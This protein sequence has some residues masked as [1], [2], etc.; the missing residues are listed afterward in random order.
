MEMPTIGNARRGDGWIRGGLALTVV[1]FASIAVS[2][3]VG[4]SSY[5]ANMRSVA[6]SNSIHMQLDDLV[7]SLK[8][9]QRGARGYIIT[10]D[11]LFLAPFREG[12]DNVR[13]EL[14]AIRNSPRTGLSTEGE[15]AI[16]QSLSETLIAAT[17]VEV[18]F[19][20]RGEP[21][22][23]RKAVRGGEP[24]R[25]MERVGDVVRVM[26]EKEAAM[27][28]DRRADA[29]SDF[30]QSLLYLLLGTAFNLTLIICM[31]MFMNRQLRN[32]RFSAETLKMSEQRLQT[33]INSVQEGITF[34]NSE[35]G[36]EVFNKRMHQIT[37]YTMEE[38]NRSGDFT[39]LLYPDPV[40]R[41]RALDGTREVIASPGPHMSE[42]TI[43]SKSGARR[44][45]QV[46]SQTLGRD[47]R[48]MFLTT[49]VDVTEQRGLEE[50]LR[51]S[52]EKF[53]LVFENAQDGINIFE[54]TADH[55]KRRLVECNPRYAELAGRSREELLAAGITSAMTVSLSGQNVASIEGGTAFSGAFSWIR[56]DGKE[57][58]IEYTA[59]PIIMRGKKFTIGIDRDVTMSRKAELLVHESQLRYQQLFEASPNPLM[60][61]DAGTLEFLQVNP[62]TIEHYGYS[63]EEF[64]SMTAKDIQPPEDVPRFLAVATAG[65]HLGER[66][67]TWRHRKKDGTIIKVRIKS[68]AIDWKG[69]SARL[70]LVHDITDLLQI[71]E[72]L[73]VQ[74]THFE[75]LFESAPE[76]IALLDGSGKVHDINR[77][78]A[79]MFGFTKDDILGR[80]ITDMTIPPEGKEVA[81]TA[82]EAVMEGVS[83]S[84][85]AQRSTKDGQ[86]IDVSIIAV[87]VD[88]GRG[89]NMAYV[90]YRDITQKKRGDREREELILQL[91]KAL[92]EVKTLGGLLPICAWCK[93]VRDDQG[94][95]HQIETYIA[96]H[97]ETKF[98]HG[99]CPDCREK[100]DRE[101]TDEP[102][103][104]REAPGQLTG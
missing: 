1:I 59:M 87:P 7:S 8:D 33:V 27:L 48:R 43:T 96:R 28:S 92:A 91:Q 66:S 55:E 26:Q 2:A 95:Y 74:K 44:I 75:R 68:H 38:A 65:A 19:V 79:A 103:E 16:I 90:L 22:S 11:T 101:A 35:G 99:I 21:D 51:D 32:G 86:S 34:S 53:R 23:A 4:M 97:S 57:N 30:N 71:E 78:F 77:A 52:E 39:R 17:E 69:R 14:A 73:R 58:V 81:R 84:L 76:G 13:R 104:I 15:I 50:T 37:G 62:A 42:T 63:P 88:D 70:V 98:T 60:V 12:S 64:L 18:E 47:G 25:V 49:Y 89:T 80:D 72:E 5:L 83:V 41:Q 45:L 85:D 40:D 9:I 82:L 24:N 46:A 3:Y 10:G 100:F 54:E 6:A 93:K 31:F 94:Y 61:Y 102:R 29:E 67:G 36:F 56:P 20:R